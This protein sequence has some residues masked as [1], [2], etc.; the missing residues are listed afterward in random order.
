[1][2]S[3]KFAANC[4]YLEDKFRIVLFQLG[5]NK[6]PTPY[7]PIH[8]SELWAAIRGL[9]DK[10]GNINRLMQ[11]TVENGSIVLFDPRLPEYWEW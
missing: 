5:D 1:M 10:N 4:L 7:L 2:I 9:Q 3:N 8:N 6:G 11:F